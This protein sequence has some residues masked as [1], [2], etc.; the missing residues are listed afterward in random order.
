M[1]RNKKHEVEEGL[2]P[3][4][5]PGKELDSDLDGFQPE[6]QA[7]EPVITTAPKVL[8]PATEPA[9]SRRQPHPTTLSLPEEVL[10]IPGLPA[11][12][13]SKMG[14]KARGEDPT[15]FLEVGVMVELNGVWTPMS[16]PVNGSLEKAQVVVDEK[17]VPFLLTTFNTY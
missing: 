17:I 15:M 16:Y 5:A 7:R 9:I 2:E 3:T 13:T 14:D 6:F 10:A 8:E 4:S 1:A 11:H 12:L